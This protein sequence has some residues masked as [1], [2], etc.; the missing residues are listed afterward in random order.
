M[1]DNFQISYV[2]NNNNKNV[3]YQMSEAVPINI[4]SFHFGQNFVACI[5]KFSSYLEI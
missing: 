2:H 1:N 3:N 4:V 5:F